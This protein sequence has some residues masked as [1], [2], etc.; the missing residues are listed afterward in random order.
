MM[1]LILLKECF[2]I[3]KFGML[4]HTSIELVYEPFRVCPSLDMLQLLFHYLFIT[5][6]VKHIVYLYCP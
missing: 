6:I 2:P 1:S 4:K 3:G 5:A